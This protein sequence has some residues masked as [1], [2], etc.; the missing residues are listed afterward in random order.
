MQSVQIL[1][2]LNYPIGR[3][4]NQELEHSIDTRISVAFLKQT[5]VKYIEDSLLKSLEKGGSFEII[6]GLDFK[7]TDPKAMLYFINL[8]KE[9]KNVHIYCYGDRDENKT[10]IVFHPKIY[11]FKNKKE[12]EGLWSHDSL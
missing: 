7:T 8:S 11:L 10:D 9:N 3:I 2:N 12:T 6:A 1:S 4:I 5:G